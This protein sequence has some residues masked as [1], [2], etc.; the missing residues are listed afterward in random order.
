MR[1]PHAANWR[2][3]YYALIAIVVA[4]G[5]VMGALLSAPGHYSV[6]VVLTVN[7]PEPIYPYQ[8]TLISIN[9]I[10]TGNSRLSGLP[11]VLYQNNSELASYTLDIPAHES[12]LIRTNYTFLVPGVHRFEAVADPSM[13]IKLVGRGNA[14]SAVTD[15]VSA[16]AQPDVYTSIPNNNIRYTESFSAQPDG[17]LYAALFNRDSGGALF[18]HIVGMRPQFYPVLLHDIGGRIAVVNGAYAAYDNGTYAYVLWLQGSL[19]SQTLASVIGT[20]NGTEEARSGASQFFVLGG[21]TTIC[22]GTDAGWTVLVSYTNDSSGRRGAAC[23]ALADAYNAAEYAKVVNALKAHA[24]AR[25]ASALFTYTNSS[26]LVSVVSLD[27]NSSI[28]ITNI[29]SNAYGVFAGRIEATQQ[30]LRSAAAPALCAGIVSSNNG[31]NVC[32]VYM[33]TPYTYNSANSGAPAL[34]NTT[35]IGSNYTVSLYSMVNQTNAVPAHYA[36]ASLIA[37]LGISDVTERWASS[38]N[39]TC[40]FAG[41]LGC[42]VVSFNYSAQAATLNLTNTGANSIR[43]RELDCYAFAAGSAST[44]NSVLAPGGSALFTV[45]CNSLAGPFVSIYRNYTLNVSY[46]KANEIR[47]S[48]GEMR[49]ASFG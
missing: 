6:R 19:D 30:A 20:F 8:N 16:P 36:A 31:T 34:I 49:V 40:G 33:I 17:L 24:A 44:F 22:L 37:H 42:K 47:F 13:L 1:A 3:A 35:A 11:V 38:F 5:A 28:G 18:D 27:A 26:A 32:S 41:T 7:A 29:F 12:A 21:N 46:I 9:V 39:N 10:N 14:S 2:I 25:R 4:G 48:K 23:G 45:M 43:V 15:V